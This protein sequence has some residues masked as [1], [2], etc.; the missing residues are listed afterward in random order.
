M[1]F[2]LE[3]HCDNACLQVFQV[4]QRKG[5]ERLSSNVEPK[6]YGKVKV[7]LCQGFR[8]KKL[9]VQNNMLWVYFH[10]QDWTPSLKI[11]SIN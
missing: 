5:N 8:F 1:Q 7:G 6:F 10:T 11:G 9:G 3:L 2:P 4:L